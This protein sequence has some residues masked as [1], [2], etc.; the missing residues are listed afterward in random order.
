MSS[1]VSSDVTSADMPALL[2]VRQPQ[3]RCSLRLGTPG[4]APVAFVI[5][6]QRT[7]IGRADDATV[8]LSASA[9]SRH[10]A[11]ITRHDGEHTIRDLGS[12]HGIYLNG[13]RISSADLRDG[14]VIQLANAVLTFEEG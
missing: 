14:D 3:R 13:L 7:V 8:R 1:E 6:A 2:P 5:A 10:H 11:E 12:T 9:V 4:A